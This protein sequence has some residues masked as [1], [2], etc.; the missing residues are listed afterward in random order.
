MA[1]KTAFLP[2]KSRVQIDNSQVIVTEWRIPPGGATGFH[3]HAMDYVITPIIG[4]TLTIVDAA[5]VAWCRRNG[6]RRILYPRG[7]R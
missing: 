3:R 7:R 2:A 1:E 4:G 6:C 5:G